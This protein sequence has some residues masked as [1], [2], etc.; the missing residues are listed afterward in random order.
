MM[1][2][3]HKS[4]HKCSLINVNIPALHDT[5]VIGVYALQDSR[6]LYL[7]SWNDSNRC[8]V[9]YRLVL[10]G[11]WSRSESVTLV[12]EDSRAG[13]TAIEIQSL[14]GRASS[15]KEIRIEQ[16][17]IELFKRPFDEAIK[18]RHFF[19]FKAS[20]QEIKNAL[21]QIEETIDFAHTNTSCTLS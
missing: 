16:E 8:L 4:Y 6:T 5:G 14:R 18:F 15:Y 19:D 21:A 1:F 13:N 9:T 11:C 20:D 17:E 10:P 2:F 3:K 7:E 12:Y